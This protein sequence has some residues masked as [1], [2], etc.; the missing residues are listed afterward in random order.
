MHERDYPDSKTIM[1][2]SGVRI[3]DADT[4]TNMLGGGK[5]S[6][7]IAIEKFLLK[8]RRTHV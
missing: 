1:R 4:L 8:M 5:A 7:T 6:M 3:P 2:I